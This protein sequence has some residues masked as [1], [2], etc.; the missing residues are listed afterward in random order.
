ME[1]LRLVK[2]FISIRPVNNKNYSEFNEIT[3][4]TGAILHLWHDINT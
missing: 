3:G 4:N 1:I 2:G